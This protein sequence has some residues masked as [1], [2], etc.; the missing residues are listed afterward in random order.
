[1]IALVLVLA[2]CGATTDGKKDLAKKKTEL[3]TLK[4]EQKDINIK[5]DSLEAQIGRL[6][7]SAVKEEKPSW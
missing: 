7:T 1:M 3:E 5:I 6:D 2:A 4:K